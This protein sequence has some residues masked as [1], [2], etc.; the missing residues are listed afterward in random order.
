MFLF[1]RFTE[2]YTCTVHVVDCVVLINFTCIIIVID[3]VYFYSNLCQ[4][5]TLYNCF[6]FF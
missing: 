2:Q 6:H 1:E 3:C 5:S 4:V